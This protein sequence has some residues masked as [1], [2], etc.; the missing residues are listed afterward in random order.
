VWLLK[1]AT[2]TLAVSIPHHHHACL[3]CLRLLAACRS[4]SLPLLCELIQAEAHNFTHK[5]ASAALYRLS[6][7]CH[8]Y[9]TQLQSAHLTS[10]EA[11]QA[12]WVKY[13][14]P[15]LRTLG[16]LLLQHIDSADPWTVSI[17]L[18]AYGHLQWSEEAVVEALSMRGMQ[19][20]H[21]YNT[22][23]CASSLVG[24]ARLSGPRARSQREFVEQLMQ[25]THVL[26]SH[27]DEWTP[28]DITSVVW[29]LSQL[30]A[31]G[32]ARRPL[33]QGLVEM[34]LWRL[35][36]FGVKEIVIT[37]YSLGRLRMRLPAQMVK[38]T[39]QIMKR[40]QELNPQDAANLVYSC[41]KVQFKQPEL[42][43]KLPEVVISQLSS[44]KPQ[45]GVQ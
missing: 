1:A 11:Q 6:L 28:A 38:L 27:V 29:A 26:L 43:Q 2:T 41:A 37:T 14:D 13:V 25:H 40:L 21:E 15:A 22:V 4:G 8:A 18:W 33:L 5:V 24:L 3:A 42:L 30:G 23:D 39:N 9:F 17:S 36:E 19:L 45:V 16:Q 31:A 10:Q 44:F 20:L 34:T 7:L 35:Q 12:A 32:P